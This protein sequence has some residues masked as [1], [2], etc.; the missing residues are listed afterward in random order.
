[1]RSPCRSSAGAV[2]LGRKVPAE[3]HADIVSLRLVILPRG[4]IRKTDRL[5]GRDAALR[6]LLFPD[7]QPRACFAAVLPQKL[8]TQ[9]IG[10]PLSHRRLAAHQQHIGQQI[11]C[12]ALLVY[13][14]ARH[15]G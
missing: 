1:M 8:R 6:P 7:R 10:L 4:G 13:G 9:K 5:A 12:P 2:A 11:I 3:G 14:Q 15:T